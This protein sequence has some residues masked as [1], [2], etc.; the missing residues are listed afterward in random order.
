MRSGFASRSAL[1]VSALHDEQSKRAAFNR[2]QPHLQTGTS[3]GA[4]DE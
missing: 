3:S 1:H 2:H 4:G